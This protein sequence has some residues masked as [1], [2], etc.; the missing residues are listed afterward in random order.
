M[1]VPC[2][3]ASPPLCLWGGPTRAN[4]PPLYVIYLYV[5]SFTVPPPFTSTSLDLYLPTF[6][7]ASAWPLLPGFDGPNCRT[8][9]SSPYRQQRGYISHDKPLLPLPP[10]AH[11]VR[12]ILSYYF[13]LI[14]SVLNYIS[15]GPEDRSALA[16]CGSSMDDGLDD[17]TAGWGSGSW[18]YLLGG[19]APPFPSLLPP[20][21]LLVMVAILYFTST[22]RSN[23]GLS[24]VACRR[25]YLHP[26]T[27]VR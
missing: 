17:T 7:L 16:Q 20:F 1:V 10:S 25:F 14:L 6:W 12:L 24:G 2:I 22:I 15:M 18:C 21:P 26:R 5:S 4:W 27:L 8:A 19:L 23:I 3:F 9:F 13:L 11:F